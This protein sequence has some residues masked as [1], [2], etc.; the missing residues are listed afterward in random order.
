MLCSASAPGR[1]AAWRLA[2]IAGTDCPGRC[3]STA[4]EWMKSNSLLNGGAFEKSRGA[5]YSIPRDVWS[6]GLMAHSSRW[7]GRMRYGPSSSWE[8]PHD[9]GSASRDPAS[10][11]EL[12]DA[13]P[14]P[15]PQPEDRRKVEEA[16]L[17]PGRAHW[18]QGA[19]LDRAVDRGGGCD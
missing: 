2:R 16:P 11:R 12:E 14:A 7:N 9:G 17:D 19:A 18:P 15:R 10:S 3:S 5:R 1:M 4:A 8:R 13:G 6:R